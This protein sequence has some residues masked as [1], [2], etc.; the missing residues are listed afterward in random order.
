MYQVQ[1]TALDPRPLGS[2][3]ELFTADHTRRD[4]LNRTRDLINRRYGEFALAPARLLLP[5]D[6]LSPQHCRVFRAATGGRFWVE[7]LD[8]LN[9][10]ELN[11]KPVKLNVLKDADRIKVGG[12]VLT[13]RTR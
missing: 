7:D 6:L 11:D 10:S 12:F 3:L 9:G 1:V 5:S 4:R 8:S 2:Q 13:F